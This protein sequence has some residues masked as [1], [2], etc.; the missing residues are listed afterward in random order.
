MRII[1]KPPHHI[2][3]Y[4]YRY[5]LNINIVNWS[6]VL[7]NKNSSIGSLH[8]AKSLT[9]S[10][11]MIPKKNLSMVCR[12]LYYKYLVAFMTELV[13]MRETLD[14]NDESPD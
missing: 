10:F 5:F 7:N 4:V 12:V 13:W 3:S 14:T 9:P 6:I 1:V 8:N 2:V 11:I